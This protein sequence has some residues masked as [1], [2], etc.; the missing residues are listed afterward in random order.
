VLN[1]STYTGSPQTSVPSKPKSGGSNSIIKTVLAC[2]L[3]VLATLLV[4]GVFLFC[5]RARRRRK[6]AAKESFTPY[7][8][9]T[10]SSRKLNRSGTDPYENQSSPYGTRL[11]LI[12]SGEGSRTVAPIFTDTSRSVESPIDLSPV[13]ISDPRHLML[14]TTSPRSSA[15]QSFPSP[16]SPPRSPNRGRHAFLP[17]TSRHSS[18]DPLLTLSGSNAALSSPVG[19]ETYHSATGGTVSTHRPLMLHDP[20]MGMPYEQE[21]EHDG[22]VPDLKREVLAL[23]EASGSTGTASRRPPTAQRRRRD[24]SLEYV[25][26]RDAGRVLELPPRYEEL[27]WDEDDGEGGTRPPAHTAQG[28]SEGTHTR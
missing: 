8:G 11:D 5:R 1:A 16:V 22:D 17:E 23:G 25:V 12:A 13:D 2:V 4:V 6:Q 28:G 3:S 7:V 14:G 15:N 21:G 24:D 9:G 26:H 18:L 20:L 27:T 10:G 19:V